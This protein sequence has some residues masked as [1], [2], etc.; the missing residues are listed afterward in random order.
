MSGTSSRVIA[1][2][3][4]LSTP[5]GGLTA[6]EVV[7][8]AGLP[9]STGYRIL[10]ELQELGLVHRGAERRLIANFS[11]Q[12]RLHCPGLEPEVLA[13]ACAKL[14]ADMTVAAEVVVLSGHNML[15][16]IVEQHPEQAIRL[17]A[18]PGFMRAAYELDSISRLALAHRSVE[19]LEK[20][21]DTG[22]F[23]TAGVD[24]RSLDW[25]EARAMI[26]AVDRHD[27]QHDMMG[28]AKG[29]RRYCVAIHDAG[30]EMICLLTVAEAATPLRDEAA[31]VAN[32]RAQ[33]MARKSA[34]ESVFSDPA[35]TG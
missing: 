20:S 23:Y 15:W 4:A 34:I 29:I 22:A 2:L 8:R 6:Q 16:H 18:F 19:A 14:S 33:L 30:G 32:V 26:A 1:I 17:R 31:H 28:N 12:R 35:Q 7:E 10:T 5:E 11:F 27:M 9:A 25:A 24:R 21:F 13:Q 3:D